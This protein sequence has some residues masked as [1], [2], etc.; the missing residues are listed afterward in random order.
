MSIRPTHY[1]LLTFI[2]ICC[3][4]YR[5]PNF[6]ET[7]D[8]SKLK[9]VAQELHEKFEL[10]RSCEYGNVYFELH[11]VEKGA[12]DYNS[13]KRIRYWA[14]EN[15]YFR[16]DEESLTDGL[17]SEATKL[18]VRPDGYTKSVKTE[19]GFAVTQIG[20]SEEGR[21]LIEVASF[22]QASTR[23]YRFIAAECPFGQVGEHTFSNGIS[24]SYASRFE[25][26]EIS[27]ENNEVTLL[28]KVNFGT[29][30]A[31]ANTYLVTYDLDEGVL[32]SY[33][34]KDSGKDAD[35]ELL[36]VSHEYD[37]QRLR[38]IPARSVSS[39][40]TTDELWQ[41][42]MYTVT[43]TDWSPVPMEVFEVAYKPPKASSA[44]QLSLLCGASLM[45]SAYFLYR[46]RTRRSTKSE[47]R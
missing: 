2:A 41:E 38:H 40:V 34:Q 16:V 4:G 37:F 17:E 39:C 9:S 3:S 13:E 6:A 31:A 18:I 8:T 43:D 23:C 30:E 47:I 1:V 21:E 45:V 5:K 11:F 28:S 22:F 20:P 19:H 44:R 29:E 24:T 7:I 27:C 12:N 32:L 42:I 25:P 14:R 26:L 10:I 46:Y 36:K 35:F 33:E 15:K